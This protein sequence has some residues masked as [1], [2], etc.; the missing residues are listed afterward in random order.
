VKVLPLKQLARSQS[1]QF[2]RHFNHNNLSLRICLKCAFDT[3]K[4]DVDRKS[5]AVACSKVENVCSLLETK[6]AG[7]SL[8]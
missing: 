4:I 2:F 6:A 3:I 8:K 5:N 7:D 1:F